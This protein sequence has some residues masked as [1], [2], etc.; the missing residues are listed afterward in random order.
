MATTEVKISPED[1]KQATAQTRERIPEP[2]VVVIFGA[3]GDLTKRKLL[4]ALFHLEQSKLLPEQIRIVGVARRD[5]GSSFAADMREGILEFGGV[6]EG[7]EKLDEFIGKVSYHAMNFDDGEGYAKLKELLE[8]YDREFGTRGNR[9]FY[10]ATAPEYFSDI[11]HRLGDHGMSH[12]E[13]GTARVII[14]KPFGHDLESARELNDDV[15]RVFD[16]NQIFRIDHYLGKETVQNILVFRFA[17]GIFEPIWNRNYV[18]HVQ[19]TAAE[20][21]GIEGRG[22]FYEKAGALRDVVQNH[23]ME[24]LSF[25]GMEPP[26]SFAA[27]EVRSEKVKLWKAIR[28]IDIQNVVRGQY[29]PGT[30]GGKAV[31]GYREEERVD[32]KSQTE[33]YAAVKL[34][35]E[36]WRWAGVPF[37]LRAGKRLAKRVTEVTVQFRQPPLL[38]FGGGSNGACDIQP[39]RITMRIQPDEGISLRFGAKVP[40]PETAVCPVV[41]DF[42]YANAFGTSSANGYERLLLDA[43][44]GDATLFAHRDGVEATWSLYTPVLEAWANKVPKTFPN[45]ASGAWGPQCGDDLL[46]RDGRAWH[47]L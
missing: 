6:T 5:L 39:N 40:G 33:T 45:Y 38:L 3:S 13:K 46:E 27:D 8:G 31:K 22:P 11:I 26:V 9:L 35:I 1:V 14:E 47:K 7:A 18:D 15:N 37:Y 16:E 30:V 19:I 34:E 21:I 12:P 10:L 36:N 32:P 29:G 23:V 4:P 28:P 2:C 42:S 43:M 17:N 25:V 41:M 44:L 24:L 20:N